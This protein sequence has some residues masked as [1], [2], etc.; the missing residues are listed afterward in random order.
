MKNNKKTKIKFRNSY[1]KKKTNYIWILS[2]T[3]ITFLL[4][5]CWEY[6]SHLFMLNSSLLT[7]IILLTLII[8]IGIFFDLLGIAVTASKEKPFHAMASRK[9][10]GAKESITLVRNAGS[11]ANFFNDV[12][13]DISGIISGV[14]IITILIKINETFTVR[15]S[16]ISILLTAT[17]AALTVGGKA[18]GKEIG[19]RKSNEIVFKLGFFLSFFTH[20]RK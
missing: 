5:I 2:I 20:K 8:F 9:V 6:F 16:V 14:T 17:V 13:G 4:A 19:I 3:V 1:T 15:T 18:I 10:R 12:I 7:S 11:V